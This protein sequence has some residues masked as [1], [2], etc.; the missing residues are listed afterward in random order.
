MDGETIATPQTALATSPSLLTGQ[1]F[2]SL[3]VIGVLEAGVHVV[4]LVV[5]VQ[6]LHTAA[7]PGFLREPLIGPFG[8][9]VAT[10]ARTSSSTSSAALFAPR[11]S[12]RVAPLLAAVFG[13]AVAPRMLQA[14]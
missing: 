11:R 5:V 13:L 7:L 8:V 3:T 9:V 2:S 10:A 4:L 12:V 14:V 1:G 6:A